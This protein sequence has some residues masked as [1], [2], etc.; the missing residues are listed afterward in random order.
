MCCKVKI[1]GFR[2]RFKAPMEPYLEL[3]TIS[4]QI[5]IQNFCSWSLHFCNTILMYKQYFGAVT[6]ASSQT[7]V[8]VR[9]RSFHA[10]C[11]DTA[12]YYV[13]PMSRQHI[14]PMY[15]NLTQ[16]LSVLHTITSALNTI[17]L[18]SLDLMVTQSLCC[19]VPSQPKLENFVPAICRTHTTTRKKCKC[20][21]VLQRHKDSTTHCKVWEQK[22]V[23]VHIPIMCTMTH[24]MILKQKLSSL[25]VQKLFACRV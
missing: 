7:I 24:L 2:T 4:N 8:Q 22:Q 14:I 6:M 23:N 16:C 10:S 13:I 5:L 25:T 18:I 19:V 1:Y 15:I 17:L 11:M 20:L 9:S 12:L 3:N 21:H